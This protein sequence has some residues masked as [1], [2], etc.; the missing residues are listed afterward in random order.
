[1]RTPRNWNSTT[2]STQSCTLNGLYSTFH[3]S[4]LSTRTSTS[5]MPMRHVRRRRQQ[6]LSL[7]RCW[8]KRQ[9]LSGAEAADIW[10]KGG[11]YC[12][13][14]QQLL[15]RKA[16]IIAQKSSNY[17]LKKQRFSRHKTKGLLL[18]F[19]RV[20]FALQKESFCNLKGVLLKRKRTTFE[21]G[22]GKSMK[23]NVFWA[24]SRVNIL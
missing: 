9:E 17:R 18:P 4:F 2:V 14:K 16:A 24:I 21:N 13:K 20:R 1:M 12:L 5:S 22:Y 8:N 6:R 7:I 19:K 15:L 23:T 11:N 10:I 3:A